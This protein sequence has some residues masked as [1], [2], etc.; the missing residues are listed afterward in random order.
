MSCQTKECLDP[1]SFL[2]IKADG[3]VC[4]CCWSPPVG[5]INESDLTEIVT[6]PKA[7]LF[8][9]S[10][11]TGELMNC[12]HQCP[13]R[14]N[15]S[16]EALRADVQLYLAD[17][18]KQYTISQGKLTLSQPISTRSKLLSKTGVKLWLDRI[19]SPASTQPLPGSAPPGAAGLDGACSSERCST[20]S[21]LAPTDL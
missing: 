5:N 14:S 15:T 18:E 7:Q 4:L 19:W 3:N 17:S 13:A 20:G 11:L 9:N 6:G 12:C 2:I 8:R 21:W 10:L 1:W 16:T